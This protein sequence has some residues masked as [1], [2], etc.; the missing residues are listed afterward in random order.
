MTRNP[1]GRRAFGTQ[2]YRCAFLA[3][4]ASTVGMVVLLA[5]R[6][7]VRF[8]RK[9][10]GRPRGWYWCWSPYMYSGSVAAFVLLKS[11]L[12][13]RT[14]DAV[15][16]AATYLL[17]WGPMIWIAFSLFVALGS[18]GA[19]ASLGYARVVISWRPADHE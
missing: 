12:W 18:V 19:A 11:A 5:N 8:D 9:G 15:P 3:A 17:Y 6:E 2:R 4:T 7:L 10:S 16:T 14:L 13:F 1:S